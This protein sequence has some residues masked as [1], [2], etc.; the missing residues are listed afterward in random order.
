MRNYHMP[1]DKHLEV[2]SFKAHEWQPFGFDC[3]LY[4]Q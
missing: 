2:I 3:I 4:I 1:L